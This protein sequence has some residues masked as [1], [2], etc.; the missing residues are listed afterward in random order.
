MGKRILKNAAVALLAS[1]LGGWAVLKP[2]V[3][4]DG[5]ETSDALKYTGGVEVDI[6][7]GGGGVWTLFASGAVAGHPRMVLSCAHLN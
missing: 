7:L 4:P 2:Q 6:P 5:E 1:S 3:V